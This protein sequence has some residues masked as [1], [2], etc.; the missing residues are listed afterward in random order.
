MRAEFAEAEVIRTKRVAL[1]VFQAMH[2]LEFT[3]VHEILG[4]TRDEDLLCHQ[5]RLVDDNVGKRPRRAASLLV[6]A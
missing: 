5:V 1:C 2:S 4:K 3:T 6:S